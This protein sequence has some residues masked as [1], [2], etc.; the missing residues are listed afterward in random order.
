MPL[1]ALEAGGVEL[2][3]PFY[4]ISEFQNQLKG[5]LKAMFFFF[6]VFFP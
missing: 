4:F 1:E 5:S 6:F 3:K 2:D